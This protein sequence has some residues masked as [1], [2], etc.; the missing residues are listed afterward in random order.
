M[1]NAQISRI[2]L[3]IFGSALILAGLF[4]DYLNGREPISLGPLQWSVLIVGLLV[5][6]AG[7][8]FKW[9]WA[10]RLSEKI[11]KFLLKNVPERIFNAKKQW[12]IDLIVIVVFLVIAI[13][14][15][16]G[17]WK[18]IAPV[19]NL[20]SD[21]ANVATYAAVLDNPEN[22]VN[23]FLYNEASNFS[24][25]VSFHIPYLRTFANQMGG[26]GL[27]YLSLLIPIIFIQSVGFYCFGKSL[28]KNRFFALLLAILS[29]VLVYTESSD[30]WGIYKDPQP[31][32][33][34]G[35]FLPWL[36]WI[37]YASLKRPALRYL[38]MAF[39][40]LM[41]YL[42]PLSSPGVA[43]AIWL[44]FLFNK[45]QGK[46][47]RAHLLEMLA[48][49]LIFVTAAIPFTITYLNSRDLAPAG[50][51]YGTALEAF[52]TKGMAMFELGATLQELLKIISYTLL[53][54]LAV[55]AW[56]VS[57]FK[58]NLKTE[59]KLLLTWILGLLFV[60][61]GITLIEAVIDAKMEI[62][63][64]LL[65]LNRDLR[66]TVPV[67]EIS[68]LLPLAALANLIQPLNWKTLIQRILVMVSGVGIVIVLILGFRSVTI[69][70]LDLKGYAQQAV[71]CWTQGR[72]FCE[73]SLDS[74][75]QETLAYISE[76]TK[77]DSGFIS[78]PPVKM[79]KLI[80]YQGLRSVVFESLE[81][82]SLLTSN[83]SE[84]F[85]IQPEVEQWKEI[86]T[87]P[88]D[89]ER[90]LAYLD[91]ASEC[92]ADYAVVS[93]SEAGQFLTDPYILV[94]S[95]GDYAIVQIP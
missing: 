90:F 54:P 15:F 93:A 39:V 72:F 58:L 35:A 50:V 45:P 71:K 2:L 68:I 25:Y 46:K 66:Y 92:G 16:A 91:F 12:I 56:I 22:F 13:A 88:N 65:Q 36:L 62:M 84:Y 27:A 78:L 63:P 73:V 7:I 64:V 19:I 24:Y 44:G 28:F 30:Y 23:D 29:L 48:L 60:G 74:S 4:F 5:L 75:L 26:Y 82:K 47:V 94:F 86:E 67:M 14:F 85:A 3:I 17:R 11:H 49:G 81:I 89:A 77:P 33:L 83:M 9:S 57:W 34:F 80:R 31:R 40:G 52:K 70:K 79:S 8:V 32:M 61:S 21:A 20:G 37:A 59:V 76:N 55:V 95:S 18:G 87:I 1:K 69:E 53:L 41:L 6:L 38:T 10:T 43:F 42:H 51:D